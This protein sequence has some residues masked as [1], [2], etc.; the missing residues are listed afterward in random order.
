MIKLLGLIFLLYVNGISTVAAD[1][2]FSFME[3]EVGYQTEVGPSALEELS[4]LIENKQHV[5][6]LRL[7]QML[8]L[9]NKEVDRRALKRLA[10][11][12]SALPF[13]FSEDLG[14]APSIPSIP[15]IDVPT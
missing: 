15:S 7:N 2:K 4:K 9:K 11:S 5:S 3:G 14:G 13:E 12:I 1:D 6:Q 8:D 10:K